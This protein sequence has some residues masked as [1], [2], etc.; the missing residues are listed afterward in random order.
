MFKE[1]YT[2]DMENVKPS[3]EALEKTKEKMLAAE[4]KKPRWFTAKRIAAL[5]ACLCLIIGSFAVVLLD[6]GKNDK[7]KGLENPFVNEPADDTAVNKPQVPVIGEGMVL[8][9]DSDY[10]DI[11]EKVNYKANRVCYFDEY[12]KSDME[13]NDVA[14]V[15]FGS[16]ELDY[17]DT[18]NQVAGV[19]E[20]DIIKTDGKY[21]YACG[22]TRE[23]LRYNR[24]N[25]FT[26]Y[27]YGYYG[28]EKVLNTTEE[29]KGRV[30]ILSA[31]DG[32]LD[33]VSTIKIR[34]DE[35]DTHYFLKDILLYGDT[36]ILI[37]SGYKYEELE[38]KDEE[39]DKYNS[40][41]Y[42]R[43]TTL[44]SVEIYDIS[45]RD[46]PVFKNELYQSGS[47]NSSRMTGSDL[48]IVTTYYVDNPD[49]ENPETYVPYCSSY[50]DKYLVP[51]DCI[52]TEENISSSVYTVITGIDV[53]K[54]DNHIS[55]A[56]V[57]GSVGT[58]YCSED[59]I[60]IASSG[61]GQVIDEVATENKNAENSSAVNKDSSSEKIEKITTNCTDIYR[62]SIKDATV[63]YTA[64]GRVSGRL[65]NQFAMD[66]YDGS[67]RVATTVNENIYT[68]DDQYYKF[69]KYN[70]V[71]IL[72]SNLIV[73]GS[74]TKMAPD[75]EIYSVRFDG[76]IG[77]VVTF[78]QVD[79]LFAIDLK[80][81]TNPKILS[82][83]KIP[84]FSSYMHPYGDGLLL[85]IGMD[86]N[87]T[88]ST[89]G[90]KLSMFDVSDK[91]DVTEKSIYKLG[92]EYRY[93]EALNN[94]KAILVDAKKNI[95]GFPV[96][97][98]GYSSKNEYV[99]FAYNNGEFE[100]VGN[101]SVSDNENYKGM[102]GL[103]IGD[104]VYIFSENNF[105]VS[106]NL[107]NFEKVDNVDFN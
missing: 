38:N 66:E 60:Y 5:A 54:P 50:P 8:K 34:N 90:I 68:K 71:Y 89:R 1:K 25:I 61:Y 47:Y 91:T 42:E 43:V 49:E 19:Q 86:A 48:Y 10:E 3:E 104:Y 94:H 22:K 102:R 70:N 82:A 11:F 17:S 24:F 67:L 44:T 55:T 35:E 40:Y 4:N 51:S 53:T 80:D 98:Y 41:K 29:D 7:Y 33:L 21:I 14:S 65:I 75:E 97:S 85:G 92:Y 105:I 84:G 15:D 62:F 64:S 36:L 23:F 63:I 93:S 79:P 88:G 77:Y 81:K 31:D 45:D 20:A 9:A 58:V 28:Y 26:D 6:T 73:T 12:I 69:E 106:Y 30:Y 100:E 96:N 74:I 87:E 59:N 32:E 2:H 37:K 83:L 39:S 76:D 56:S 99:F 101:I 107:S 13:M 27:Y 18:N 46:N 103:Y 52:Y 95:I 72:D 16:K 78:R 57:L